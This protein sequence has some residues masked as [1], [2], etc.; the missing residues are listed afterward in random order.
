MAFRIEGYDRD[1]DGGLM[2]RLEH[3][4]QDG[5]CTGWHP[6]RIGLGPNTALVATLEEWLALFAK[7]GE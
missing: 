5:E 4:D 3:I 6:S 2:A 1:C 7:G